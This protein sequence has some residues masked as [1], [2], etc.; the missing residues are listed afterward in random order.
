M[1]AMMNLDRAEVDQLYICASLFGEKGDLA[2]M[3]WR[4]EGPACLL[5]RKIADF[6]E[7]YRGGVQIVKE[8]RHGT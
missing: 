5:A 4:K 8:G 7:D 2:G 1:E 3:D 6:L